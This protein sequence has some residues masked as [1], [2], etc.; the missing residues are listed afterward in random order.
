MNISVLKWL[1]RAKVSEYLAVIQVGSLKLCATIFSLLQPQFVSCS[2]YLWQ[3]CTWSVTTNKTFAHFG[4]SFSLY[5]RSAY[6]HSIAFSVVQKILTER[7]SAF[8]CC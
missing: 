5:S 2:A 8:R 3:F 7:E 4:G 6:H 1:A